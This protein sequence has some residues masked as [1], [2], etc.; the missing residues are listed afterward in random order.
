MR[1]KLETIGLGKRYGERG[2]C[3][4]RS[5]GAR[6]GIPDA[7]RPVG[8]GQDHAAADDLRPD[9]AQ[10]RRAVARRR[11]RH[12]DA[13]RQAR[14]RHGVPELCAVP[15]HDGLGKRG[16]WPAHAAGAGRRAQARRGRGADDG[17]DG[18]VRAPLPARAVRRAAAAHRAG[19]LLCLSPVG[20]PAGR[21]AG[22]AG[23]EAARTHAAR[24]PP[25]ACGIAGHL[26]LRHARPGRSPGHVRPHLPDEPGPH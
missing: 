2:A 1:Y 20:D 5:A 23:Q 12:A 25:P 8:V 14:H 18:R 15:A 9:A 24:N 6:R 19:A 7:A 22:R 3:P 13:A 17:Q 21:A 4:H 10:Q 26:H 11:R 16:L